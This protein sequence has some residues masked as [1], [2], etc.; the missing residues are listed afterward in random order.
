MT[1]ARVWCWDEGYKP[2]SQSVWL[3]WLHHW[4]RGNAPYLS[5]NIFMYKLGT[6]IGVHV[7]TFK[8]TRTVPNTQERVGCRIAILENKKPGWPPWFCHF[9]CLNLCLL[10]W[11]K[12]VIRIF[13]SLIM[14]DWMGCYF[15]QKALLSIHYCLSYCALVCPP[16]DHCW[17][18]AIFTCLLIHIPVWTVSLLWPGIV[19]FSLL[20]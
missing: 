2:R 19:S 9:F 4:T 1:R 18:W 7:N 16:P 14:K 15:L 12:M 11:K 20:V 6:R 10:I 8:V 13:T 3:H 5:L 17:P